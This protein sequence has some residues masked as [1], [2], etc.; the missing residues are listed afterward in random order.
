MI[1]GSFPA[2]KYQRWENKRKK[3]WQR[4]YQYLYHKQDVMVILIL[5]SLSTAL[6]IQGDQSASFLQWK[7]C[8]LIAMESYQVVKLIKYCT[9][10]PIVAS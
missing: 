4:I 9:I 6:F 7:T 2:L 5:S 10:A 3:D 8:S 1:Y